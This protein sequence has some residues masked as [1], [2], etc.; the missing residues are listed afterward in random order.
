[1]FTILPRSAE[2]VEIVEIVFVCPICI[3]LCPEGGV[4]AVQKVWTDGSE[5][6][7]IDIYT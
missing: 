5:H 6:T 2:I 4:Q 3:C 7:R 1:M